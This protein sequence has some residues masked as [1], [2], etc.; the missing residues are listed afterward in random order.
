MDAKQDRVS[1]KPQ[2]SVAARVLAEHVL[3][4][5]DLAFSFLGSV[6]AQEG[7][8]GHRRVQASRPE[9]YQREVAVACRVETG[10]FVLDIGGRIDGVWDLDGQVVLEEIK[11][12]IQPLEAAA[13]A[14]NPVHWGQARIYAHMLAQE[15]GLAQVTVQLTY[16]HLETG[17]LKELRRTETRT[18]LAEFFE[19]VVGRYLDWIRILLA[20]RARRDAAIASLE[21]PFGRYRPGQREMA[22][23]VF[24]AA[25]DGHPLMVQAPTGIGKTMAAW[26]PAVKAVGAGLVERVFFLTA[27]TTGRL[28]A[29]DAMAR[30]RSAGLYFRVLSL[31]AKDRICFAPDATCGPE[32]CP[33]ARGHFDR[34]MPALRAALEEQALTRA[35]V[36]ALAGDHRVCP[37]EFSVSLAS[38]VDGIIGDYNY[39]F[40]PRVRLRSLFEAEGVGR[41][42]LLVD[43][44]HNLVDRGREMYS[45]DLGKQAVLAVRREVKTVAPKLYRA[46]GRVGRAI[47][48][49]PKEGAEGV[50][51]TPPEA[52]LDELKG[53]LRASEA[54]L[55]RH[56]GAQWRQAV[57]DLY[58]QMLAFA[59]IGDGY[60]RRYVT[61]ATGP[62][63]EV[64]VRLFCLDP[65]PGL[66]ETLSHCNAAVFFSATLTPMDYFQALF[67][68]PAQTARCCLPSPFPEERFGIF[69][70]S[71][72][73][74]YYRDRSRTLE[75]V[76]EAIGAA[77]DART[78]NYLVFFP[79]YAY[80]EQVYDVFVHRWPGTAVQCQTPR[81]G[82]QARDDFL[83]WFPEAPCHTRVG[84][85]VMG[86]VFGE[87][88]D[89][90]GERLTGAVVVG[91]GLPA[92]CPERE[93]IKRFFD[94]E[95]GTGFDFAYRFP[96]LNRVLQAAGRVIRSPEDRGVVVLIDARYSRSA[97]RRL[98]PLHWRPRPV[99]RIGRLAD[100]LA[101]FWDGA[102]T[103]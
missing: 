66:A 78:G 29:E 25:R 1:A 56:P 24:R 88:I 4:G 3:Q 102:Q 89:L 15:R 60:D 6:R 81:M 64:Q 80:L 48:A 39:A 84:F 45:A 101:D 86:G 13:G 40:D 53:A 49:V 27:R 91:V 35:R 16:Y 61:L 42:L 31:T 8:A 10:D 90:V 79:S 57:M 54:V 14:D 85:A 22:V 18:A 59:R 93:Q 36:E 92:I 99:G 70:L 37:F 32:D 38:H 94:G 28:A 43:E 95:M 11:T 74:T 96:G 62:A 100:G 75:P 20:G 87:G 103:D 65:S 97:Y 46:L 83:A 73:S 19:A 55:L 33:Y 67:G 58:F 2:I 52:L 72:V 51:E 12:T 41:T 71:S 23:A 34:L 50:S 5:G 77:V 21:F 76:V 98:L 44:A 7:I 63:K 9:G 30:L 17:K 82:D 69:V 68:L 47:S 26:F